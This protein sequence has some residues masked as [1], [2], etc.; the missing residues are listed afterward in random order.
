M[1]PFAVMLMQ[2]LPND[3]HS[4][5]FSDR[6]TEVKKKIHT[7]TFLL[8]C[9]IKKELSVE[10]ATPVNSYMDWSELVLCDKS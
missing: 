3:S 2:P 7:D 6:E 1:S 9:E 4:A 5:H 10:G 8:N